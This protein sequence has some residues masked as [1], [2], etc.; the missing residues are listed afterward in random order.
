MLTDH[1]IEQER[2]A[3]QRRERKNLARAFGHFIAN[4]A[5]WDWFINPLTLRNVG[6]SP[7]APR[8][9]GELLRDG[10]F[11]VCK[12]DPRLAAYQ[13]STRYTSRGGSPTP[14]AALARVQNW[15]LGVQKRAG[16][17]IGWMIAEE[18]GRLGGRWHCHGLVTGVSHLDRRAIWETAN[19]DFGYTRIERFDARRGA[20]FYSAKYA[21]R[22]AGRIHFGGTLAGVD[23]SKCE[24][25][26][27]AGGGRDVAVSVP[28][29][30]S[31][32]HMCLPRRHR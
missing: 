5:G 18:F 11:A 21:G 13:P 22:L 23:L 26:V 17:P 12:P 31:Y 24:K 25:S 29:P 14:D 6:F 2:W 15:F 10:C 9:T 1:R 8:E 28:L 30:R 3:R 16:H 4:I 19:Q 20:A 32:F 7:P 27:S